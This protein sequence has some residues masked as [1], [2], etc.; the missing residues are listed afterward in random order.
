MRSNRSDNRQGQKPD[1]RKCHGC[2]KQGCSRYPVCTTPVKA[3]VAAETYNDWGRKGTG[4][5]AW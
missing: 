1:N 5:R 4:K 2:G 3:A